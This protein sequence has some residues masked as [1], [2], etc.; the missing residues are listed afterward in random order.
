MSADTKACIMD[1]EKHVKTTKCCS[2]RE[3]I[4][5]Q[6]AKCRENTYE[7]KYFIN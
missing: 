6:K 7:F 3:Q 4:I 5:W 2:L 1:K